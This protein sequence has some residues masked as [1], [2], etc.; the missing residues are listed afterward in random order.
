MRQLQDE[1]R[2]REAKNGDV[3]VSAIVDGVGAVLRAG[4]ETGECVGNAVGTVAKV[5]VEVVGQIIGGA[6]DGL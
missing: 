1:E 3:M 4:V 6:L 5:G 2:Q